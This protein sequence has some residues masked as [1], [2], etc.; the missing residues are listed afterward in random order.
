MHHIGQ[1]L[2]FQ[3]TVHSSRWEAYGECRQFKICS[4]CVR[5]HLYNRFLVTILMHCIPFIF[6]AQYFE[7][8]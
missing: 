1:L 4:M 8:K 2:N 6:P 7:E 5:G 3:C